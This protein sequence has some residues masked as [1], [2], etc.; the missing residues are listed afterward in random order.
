M[1]ITLNCSTMKNRDDIHNQFND[2]LGFPSIYARNMDA[3]IDCLTDA[4]A[5]TTG[6][7]KHAVESGK[8]ITIKLNNYNDLKQRRSD[9]IDDILECIAF[10]NL[11][12]IENDESPLFFIAYNSN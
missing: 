7:C 8:T 12:R 6:M 11:R 1:I 5:P 10:V 2:A 3:L 4:D 9:L